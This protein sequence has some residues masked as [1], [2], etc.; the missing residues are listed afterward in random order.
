MSI[1]LRRPGF[2]FQVYA[3]RGS[4]SGVPV[5][6]L[7]RR[8]EGNFLIHKIHGF[9]AGADGEYRRQILSGALPARGLSDG[10]TVLALRVVGKIRLSPGVF[11]ASG[12]RLSEG[13]VGDGRREESNFPQAGGDFSYQIL[14]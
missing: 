10:Y 6:S 4:R 2:D 3:S 14:V 9:W 1:K 13:V 11:L 5:H 12:I 8:D 7:Q